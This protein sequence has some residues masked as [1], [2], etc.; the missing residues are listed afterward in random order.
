MAHIAMVVGDGK[1]DGTTWLE[2]VTGDQY[3]HALTALDD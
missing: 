2:P 1:G 3:A